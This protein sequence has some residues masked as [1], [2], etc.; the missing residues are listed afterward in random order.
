MFVITFGLFLY[1]SLVDTSATS[2]L[3]IRKGEKVV[4]CQC[5]DGFDHHCQYLNTCIGRRNLKQFRWLI[6][7]NVLYLAV[8]NA[9]SMYA[10]SILPRQTSTAFLLCGLT[11][12]PGLALLGMLVLAAFQVY[13]YWKGM[14]TFEFAVQCARQHA[15]MAKQ[16]TVDHHMA[17][18]APAAATITVSEQV[19]PTRVREFA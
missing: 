17:T 5:V 10:I 11:I 8:Q 1:V 13:I 16:V 19:Q 18:M 2:D 15:K 12:L 14:P 4:R 9:V 3:P 6:L 7:W